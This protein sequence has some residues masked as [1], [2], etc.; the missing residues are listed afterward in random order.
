M[1][2]LKTNRRFSFKIGENNAW[3]TDYKTE[4]REEGERLTTVYYFANGLKVTNVAQKH[5]KYGAYEWVNYFENTAETPSEIISELWDCDCALPMEHE[6]TWKR[7]AYSPERKTATKIYAPTGST[8]QAKEFYCNIDEL[9]TEQRLNHI[10]P[11]ET[12]QYAASNGRSSEARAP[13]F[14]IHKNGKG[15]VF[16]IGWS[17]Q[18]NCAV[19]RTNDEILVRTKI[20]DTAFRMMPGESFRTSSVVILP[21]QAEVGASQNIWRRFMKEVI[22]PLGKGNRPVCAPIT[23]MLWGGMKTEEAM[24][25]IGVINDNEIPIECI[26]M[27]AGWY[28]ADTKPTPDEFEGDWAVHT[29]DWSVSPLIHPQGLKDVS[30]AVHDAGRK[31]L[32]WF[33]PE[34]VIKTTP[35]VSEHSEYFLSTGTADEIELL[36]NLGSAEAWR[37][38]FDM[39]SE[40]IETLRIDWLR[41]D[42]NFGPL[43]Y[44]RNGDEAERKGISEIKYINGLY[45]LWDALLEKFPHL[46]IDDC[47]SGG[48]RIDVETMKRSV[49]LWRSDFQCTVNSDIEA[50]QC[51]TQCFGAWLPYSGVGAGRSCDAYRVRSAYSAG[52]NFAAFFSEK[53]ALKEDDER[54][55]F[56]KKYVAE[57]K[58]VRPYFSEDFYPLTEVSDAP[59]VWCANQFHR[60]NE[61]DGM[62]QVFRREKAPYETARFQMRGLNKNADYLICDA[63]GGE[64]VMSG[65]E[66]MEIGVEIRI[67]QK[68]T[69]KIFF[70]EEKCGT[71]Q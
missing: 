3:D 2:F 30:K 1:D 40:K 50:L 4:V 65:A 67:L 64:F 42:F 47:A 41:I 24:R 69:A 43:P 15:Y 35:I 52:V 38:C 39:L 12:K 57:A 29:G 14:N 49:P 5:E 7:N 56:L 8:W 53:D 44:W 62:I 55:G 23:A 54:I 60:P 20:E 61:N 16:A 28:G 10:L 34:R 31:F 22:S 48:R 19:S 37:Y 25:R 18:W 21:Y 68:R 33:E 46:L 32:L 17:G 13:F 45:R 9:S 58:K 27:D 66:L 70:Y 11:G 26:W 59:D 36:L 71:I 63:D 6:D 51:H